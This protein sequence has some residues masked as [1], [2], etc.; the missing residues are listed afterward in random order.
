M[1]HI[2]KTI[3]S[4]QNSVTLYEKVKQVARWMFVAIGTFAIFAYVLLLGLMIAL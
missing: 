1:K 3:T 2:M 4:N